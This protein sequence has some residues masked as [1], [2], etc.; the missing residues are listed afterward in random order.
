MSIANIVPRSPFPEINQ[1]FPDSIK[2]SLTY[3][4]QKS[5]FHQ[6]ADLPLPQLNM[7]LFLG[8]SLHQI[9]VPGSV[10]HVLQVK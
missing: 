4:W 3:K 9:T 7:S 6:G 10:G 8:L 5:N 1:L 2:D